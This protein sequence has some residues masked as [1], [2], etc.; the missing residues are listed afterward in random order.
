MQC[1]LYDEKR[2]RV[3]TTPYAVPVPTEETVTLV[4]FYQTHLVMLYLAYLLFLLH[5]LLI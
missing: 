4:I 3:S 5:A 2:H 1:Q